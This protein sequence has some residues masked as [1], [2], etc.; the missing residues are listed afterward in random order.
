MEQIKHFGIEIYEKDKPFCDIAD[1]IL[2]MLAKKQLSVRESLY[3][4]DKA[5]EA[6]EASAQSVTWGSPLTC[7][8]A[9]NEVLRCGLCPE[10]FEELKAESL[11]RRK[12]RSVS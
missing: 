5:K 7:E 12:D 2:K 9:W 3:V 11:R 1:T 6:V 4:L 10:E 8:P